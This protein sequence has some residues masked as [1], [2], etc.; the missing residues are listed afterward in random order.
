ML[1]SRRDIWTY[2]PDLGCAGTHI[3]DAYFQSRPDV[4]LPSHLVPYMDAL[5]GKHCWAQYAQRQDLTAFHTKSSTLAPASL[6]LIG[7]AFH[8]LVDESLDI[9]GSLGPSHDVLIRIPKKEVDTA[10]GQRSLQLPS[11]LRRVFGACLMGI[12]DPAVETGF[13]RD[14][15]AI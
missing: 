2:D 3:L 6:F 5:H 8:A 7:Q 1:D 4:L 10:A 11:C 15:S 12:V 14:Q 13:K 9:A